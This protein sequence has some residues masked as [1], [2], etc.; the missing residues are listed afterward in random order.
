[1]N[2]APLSSPRIKPENCT[3]SSVAVA[4]SSSLMLGAYNRRVSGFGDCTPYTQ[5]CSLRSQTSDARSTL[6]ERQQRPSIFLL[7]FSA[8]ANPPKEKDS[9]NKKTRVSLLENLN[10]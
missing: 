5:F 4:P 10:G 8:L 2:I 9:A 1:L 3:N 6:S 7:R